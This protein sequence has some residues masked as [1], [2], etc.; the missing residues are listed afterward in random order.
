MIDLSIGYDK[1][2][3]IRECGLDLVDKSLL[4][5]AEAEKRGSSRVINITSN[6]SA[7][8]LEAN[9]LMLQ[10]S[11]GLGVLAVTPGTAFS[12]S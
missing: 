9:G 6:Y 7:F 8:L 5:M 2:A 11:L 4:I 3:Q 1:F 10:K 12:F